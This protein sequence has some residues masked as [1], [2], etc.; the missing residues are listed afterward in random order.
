[1]TSRYTT[2]SISV[3]RKETRHLPDFTIYTCSVAR[4]YSLH[5]CKAPSWICISPALR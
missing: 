5:T 4:I 1:M 3:K 2:A